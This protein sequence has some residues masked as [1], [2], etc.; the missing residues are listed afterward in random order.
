MPRNHDTH[1]H[2]KVLPVTRRCCSCACAK[3]Y[4]CPRDA[5]SAF[6]PALLSL[7]QQVTPRSEPLAASA[8]Q[9]DPS[10]PPPRTAMSSWL[11]GDPLL[12][13][14]VQHPV[15]FAAIAVASLAAAFVCLP[16][17]GALLRRA[18]VQLGFSKN[19]S[20]KINTFKTQHAK[21]MKEAEHNP[22]Y[23][24]SIIH[25][26]S[27]VSA[28][29]RIAVGILPNDHL[30]ADVKRALCKAD[31]GA[32]RHLAVVSVVEQFEL[33]SEFDY[34][35]APPCPNPARALVSRPCR[36]SSG[37]QQ[38]FKSFASSG[39]GYKERSMFPS[40]DYC[41]V[42]L[43]VLHKAADQLQRYLGD[44]LAVYVHCKSGK[45]RSAC[46]VCAYLMKH[47]V[48]RDGSCVLLFALHIDLVS[49]GLTATKL[50]QQSR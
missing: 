45:G 2:C 42:S 29:H 19:L 36:S 16:R 15:A 6:K 26:P 35:L 33:D 22:S 9:P 40:D 34:T 50:L 39:S 13:K 8:A 17:A 11:P 21:N 27:L 46:A 48:T 37:Q 44:G 41:A 31:D 18:S 10:P 32:P 23:A 25:S 5:R 20:T 38:H 3:V 30:L 24:F 4:I 47:Q 28:S 7:P 43:P 12:T 49:R 1:G 14:L